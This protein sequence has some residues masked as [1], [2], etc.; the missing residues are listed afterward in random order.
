LFIDFPRA[1]ALGYKLFRPLSGLGRCSH[2]RR[3][4]S[5]K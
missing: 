4:G 3:Q 1:Y 5:S 2:D